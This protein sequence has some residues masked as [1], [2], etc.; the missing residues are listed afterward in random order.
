MKRILASLICLLGLG[1]TAFA[2]IDVTC[3]DG[4]CFASGWNVTDMNS[5]EQSAVRCSGGDC[6]TEGWVSE[7]KGQDQSEIIC[8]GQGCFVDGWRTYNAVNGAQTAEVSCYRGFSGQS[9]CLI[10]G[11]ETLTQ[12]GRYPTLCLNGDCLR[13]GWESRAQGYQPQVARC[14]TGGCFNAGW[15]V[16]P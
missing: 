1:S 4:D 6:L 2:S 12:Y 15:T 16:R 3:A 11:W 14:K 10:H 5:G 7:Y 13:R 9:D 8:K